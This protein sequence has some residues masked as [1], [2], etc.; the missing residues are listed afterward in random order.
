MD[1][2]EWLRNL[3]ARILARDGFSAV[4]FENAA[5]AI[6]AMDRLNVKPAL[7]LTDRK[8]PDMDGFQLAGWVQWN[9]PGIPVVMMTA[10]AEDEAVKTQAAELGIALVAKPFESE[11]LMTAVRAALPPEATPTTEPQPPRP[12]ME[13]V[14]DLTDLVGLGRQEPEASVG[15]PASWADSEQGPPPESSMLVLDGPSVTG[16][17]GANLRRNDELIPPAP[18]GE[19]PSSASAHDP[20]VDS[21][22]DS[23]EDPGAAKDR[24][25]DRLL[26]IVEKMTDMGT[27]VARL[28]AEFRDLLRQAREAQQIHEL[29]EPVPAAPPMAAATAQP[30]GVNGKS[31]RLKSGVCAILEPL[32]Y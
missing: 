16:S 13:G 12:I 19:T 31:V 14:G 23:S 28:N 5:L 6:D 7:V 10:D 22:R 20:W 30:G 15:G 18:A 25:H 1:D 29:L 8:M 2:E 3:A 4:V 21:R 11:G 27:I 26:A 17:F 24:L 32:N 9:R